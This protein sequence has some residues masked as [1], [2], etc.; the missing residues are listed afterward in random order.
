MSNVSAVKR[1][2]E[3][4]QPPRVYSIRR[5]AQ[6][7]DVTPRTIFRMLAAGKL[8]SVQLAAHRRGIPAEEIERIATQG[9]A[10]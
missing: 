5:A 10:A 6:A 9:V 4:N 3:V 7:F 8:R 2:H 1:Q